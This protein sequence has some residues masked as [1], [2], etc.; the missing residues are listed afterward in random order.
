MIEEEMSMAQ[1]HNLASKKL[2]TIQ[3]DK[4]AKL[5]KM[6]TQLERRAMIR[7]LSI[8]LDFSQACR[9]QEMRPNRAIVLKDLLS[10]SFSSIWGKV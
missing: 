5:D 4:K 8:I 9:K 1:R 2:L 6:N 10:V 7:Y 3:L